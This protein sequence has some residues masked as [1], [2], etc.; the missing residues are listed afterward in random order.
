MG[1]TEA[2]STVIDGASTEERKRE[3][4]LYI[5]NVS[6]SCIV[7]LVKD[8]ELDRLMKSILS[9]QEV[10]PRFVT[11][12]NNVQIGVPQLQPLILSCYCE[13]IF[14]NSAVRTTISD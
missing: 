12:R 11:E 6:C 9:M 7:D 10:N 8:K 1:V 5:A 3:N 13:M 14:L 4:D 2:R